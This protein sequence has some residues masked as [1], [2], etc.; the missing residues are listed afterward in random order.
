MFTRTLV[1]RGNA[2]DDPLARLMHWFES[3][4]IIGL[5]H[6]VY[7]AS[8]TT[9]TLDADDEDSVQ[10]PT[11]RGEPTLAPNG[12]T[13]HPNKAAN[14]TKSQNGPNSKCSNGVQEDHNTH[15]RRKKSRRS[16]KKARDLRRQATAEVLRRQARG[17]LAAKS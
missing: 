7:G 17:R 6:R 3:E 14:T 16:S 12:S 13:K 9:V 8:A 5:E 2:I 10:T 15:G 11:G 1:L 4:E